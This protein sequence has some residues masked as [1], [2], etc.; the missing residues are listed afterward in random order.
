[1]LQNLYDRVV[2]GGSFTLANGQ[3]RSRVARFFNYG[4]VDTQFVPPAISTGAVFAVT[5]VQDSSPNAGKVLIAGDFTAVGGV[6]QGHLTR[7]T[8]SGARDASFNPGG[9]G[10]DGVIYA[11]VLL[12]SGKI[13][14][15]GD[16][17]TYNGINSPRLARL[18][19][20]G[21]L[22]ASFNVGVGADNTV[23]SIAVQ[24][25][26]NIVIGGRFAHVFGFPRNGVARL[27]GDLGQVR[28]QASRPGDFVLTF[29]SASGHLYIIETSSDLRTWTGLSTNI[30][31]SGLNT[32]AEPVGPVQKGWFYRVRFPAP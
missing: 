6:S 24:T 20:D 3:S 29:T 9:A 21:T 15:G 13:L 16:F 11:L 7:L 1:M 26:G 14:I 22:D 10:A 17:M 27:L 4:A 19:A 18:N 12:P 8:E 32:Y 23:Y 28:L 30:T 2:V 25:D 5:L 31:V